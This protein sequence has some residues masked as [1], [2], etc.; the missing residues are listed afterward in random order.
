MA[1]FPRI[2]LSAVV[3]Y[4]FLKC[5]VNHASSFNYPGRHNWIYEGLWIQYKMVFLSEGPSA[6]FRS[7]PLFG[8]S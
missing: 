2:E 3:V 1:H 4:R 5:E 6:F 8:Q 7:F